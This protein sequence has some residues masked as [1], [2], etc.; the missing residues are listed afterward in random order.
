MAETR[1]VWA[2]AESA[3]SVTVPNASST[4][5]T[6]SLTCAT[7]TASTLIFPVAVVDSSGA[8]GGRSSSMTSVS[9]CTVA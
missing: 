4:S 2:S 8:A 1:N 5:H 3:G 7:W 6:Q 9:T